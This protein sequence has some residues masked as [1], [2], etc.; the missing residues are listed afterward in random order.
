MAED[1]D[2]KDDLLEA[3]FL[4]KNQ[5]IISLTNQVANLKAQLENKHVAAQ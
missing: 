1:G 3:L 2:E 5:K 4:A